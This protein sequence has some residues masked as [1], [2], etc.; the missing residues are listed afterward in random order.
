MIAAAIVLLAA[1]T[2][3]GGCGGEDDG[4]DTARDEFYGVVTGE[5][6]PG[7]PQLARLGRG[8]VGTLRI[9]LP[10]GSVQSG[11]GD[12][13]DW[14]RYDALIGSAA[15]NGIR[16]F[17][18]V[19]SSPTWA[20]ATPEHPPLG[21]LEEFGDFARAAAERYG[22]D[23]AFWA[24]NPELPRL[25]ITNWEVWNEPNRTE[26][27]Q[28]APDPQQ[29]LELLRA[30]STAI[31][32]ADPEAQIVLAGLF[33]QPSPEDGIPLADFV[34]E[35]YDAGG[36]DLFDAVAVHPYAKTPD[37]AL[38]SVQET[39]R[40]MDR[41]GDTDKPI[42][43]TEVGW[44]SGGVPSGVTVGLERQAEYLTETFQLM[45]ENRDR[46]GIAGVIWYSL[47]DIPGGDLWPYHCGLFTLEG[48][49][50]PSWDA[51]VELTGGG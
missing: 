49:P 34:P 15:E 6:L 29:Y 1:L 31:K 43:L 10:W 48:T 35:L 4:G 8:E 26:F 37:D 30:V 40:V 47:T 19:Y 18:T 12:P 21:R 51:F 20:A 16:V 17:A 5:P 36:G 45:S 14:S 13:Y 38:D 3:L 33:F 22:S 39:R 24:E 25:P 32:G 27:W 46:L 42:W 44:A 2:V 9:N 28:P 7:Q 41:L 50:K 23:G 11:P